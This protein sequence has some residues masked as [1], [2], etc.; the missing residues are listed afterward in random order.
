MESTL[1]HDLLKYFIGIISIIINLKKTAECSQIKTGLS[2]TVVIKLN[3]FIPLQ[4]TG[5]CF[6]ALKHYIQN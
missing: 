5:A 4:I 1:S 6:L 3:S 2:C